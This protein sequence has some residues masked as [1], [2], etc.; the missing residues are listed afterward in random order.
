M[1]TYPMC[2]RC[3]IQIQVKQEGHSFKTMEECP[4]GYPP[5][6][7]PNEL[8]DL[9]LGCPKAEPQPTANIRIPVKRTPVPKKVQ[10]TPVPKKR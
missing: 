2:V 6:L 8:M 7:E 9:C 1:T 5:G 3:Q 10:R 4:A